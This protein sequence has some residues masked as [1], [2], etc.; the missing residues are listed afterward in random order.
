[1][2]VANRYMQFILTGFNLDEIEFL[3]SAD[4]VKT[5]GPLQG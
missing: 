4:L 2:R 1:M 5:I 3:E